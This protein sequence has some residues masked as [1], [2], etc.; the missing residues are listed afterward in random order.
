MDLYNLY[1]TNFLFPLDCYIHSIAPYHNLSFL[2]VFLNLW[3]PVVLQMITNDSEG[4]D[5]IHLAADRDQRRALVN[6][7]MN[8]RVP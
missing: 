8:L 4:V 3:H 6:T 5:W 1:K 2:K 7:V